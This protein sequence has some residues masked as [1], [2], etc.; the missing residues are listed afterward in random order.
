MIVLAIREAFKRSDPSVCIC[1]GGSKLSEDEILDALVRLHHVA[2]A[3]T[4]QQNLL[5]IE[6]LFGKEAC[7]TKFHL[8]SQGVKYLTDLQKWTRNELLR[9]SN[10]GLVKVALLEA[11]MAK[12]GLALKDEPIDLPPDEIRAKCAKE[13]VAAGQRLINH[14]TALI[15]FAVRATKRVKVGGA[16][17]NSSKAGVR[18]FSEVERV[19][20][21]LHD[22]EQSEPA[23]RRLTKRGT[24]AFKPSIKPPDAPNQGRPI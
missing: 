19:A 22:L 18:I 21:L 12:Y 16:L 20:H 6:K 17:K 13:L 11:E 5:P 2:I 10:I 7:G 23:S 9:V 1:H 8:R 3:D 14:G 15:N 4:R 24:G